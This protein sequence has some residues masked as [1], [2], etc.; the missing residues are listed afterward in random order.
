MVFEIT[1]S[2]NEYMHELEYLMHRAYP[3]NK[4]SFHKAQFPLFD[5]VHP[6]RKGIIAV[7]L[8]CDVF[9]GILK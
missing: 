9:E 8:G 2:S 4:I 3:S 7:A 5:T 6:L 1:G